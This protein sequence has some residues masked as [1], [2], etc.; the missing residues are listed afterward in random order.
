MFWNNDDFGFTD[1]MVSMWLGASLIWDVDMSDEEYDAIYD[2]ILRVMYG[3]AA[4]AVKAYIT[5]IGN[6]Y[7]SGSCAT[8]WWWGYAV[9]PSLFQTSEL[10][11][12]H[13]DTL[14]DLLEGAIPLVDS[15]LQEHRIS[16]MLCGCIYVGSMTSYFAAYNAGDD[17]R[18]TE[19]CRRYAL[20]DERTRAFGFDMSKYIPG[21]G[22]NGSDPDLEVQAWQTYK[23]ATP[24]LRPLYPDRPQREM[25]ARVAAI[26][27]E[28][29]AGY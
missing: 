1:G 27:A 22:I 11:K 15:E 6:I 28:R 29:E 10:W 2:R 3:D 13:Y 19:L 18:V 24:T 26:L 21:L 23:D 5:S 7:E 9:S 12:T 16:F 8:C 4:E 20:I 25:P 14:F 17:E